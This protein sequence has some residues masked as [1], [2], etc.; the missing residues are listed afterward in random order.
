MKPI[1]LVH[2][3]AGGVAADDLPDRAIEGCRRAAEAGYRVLQ[4]GGPALDAV[5]AAAVV[6]EDDPVFNAGTGS[7]LTSDGTVETDASIMDGDG[8]RFGAVGALVGMKNPVLL[9]RA[10]MDRTQH[11]FLVGEGAQRL[12][13]EL[14]F[15]RIDAGALITERARARFEAERARRLAPKHGTIGVVARDAKGHVAAATSTGGTSFKRPGRIGDSPL[16]GAGTYADDRGG[17]ASATGHGESILRVCLT[18]VA[19]M[20][21]RHGQSAQA[22]AETALAELAR[23]GGEGGLICVD[24]RGGHG[25]A[26]NTERM[27]RAWIAADGAGAAFAR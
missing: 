26:F 25:L 9:A 23:I 7:C 15:A 1:I 5:Q 8:L 17:A 16:P 14:G 6:L 27:A 12:A 4:Q 2:G 19:V 20:Q 11:A 13:A 22:A 24:G 21:M 10:V 18:Q 3:G